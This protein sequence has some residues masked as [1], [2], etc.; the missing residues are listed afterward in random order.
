MTAFP[1]CRA[2]LILSI[3]Q[4]MHI[5]LF[6]LTFF[7]CFVYVTCYDRLVFLKTVL[8]SV[9]VSAILYY[10]PD[11]HLSVSGHLLSDRLLS[12]FLPY[13]HSFPVGAAPQSLM[14]LHLW[15]II[16]QFRVTSLRLSERRVKLASTLPSGSR[17]AA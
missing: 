16:P 1:S 9:T 11:E 6:Q 12:Y 5:T 13:F 14:P 4:K 10:L 17:L 15:L 8:P 2:I 7:K 3:M